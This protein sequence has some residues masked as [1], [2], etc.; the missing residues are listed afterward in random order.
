MFKIYK[1]LSAVL[2]LFASVQLTN[3]QAVKISGVVTARADGQPL[4][5]VSIGVTGSTNGT[6]TD[7]QGKF[8]LNANAN[9]ILRISYIGF[10]TQ[11]IKVT[12][13][14]NP[15]QI[16]LQEAPNSLNE[17]VV[18]ALN[19]SKDKKSLGYAVQGLKSKDISE[20]KETNLVNALSGKIAGLQVTGSQGDM[21]SSRIIIRGETSV[22]GNNQPLFVVDGVI[23]D[24]SQFQGTNGSRDF[25]NAIADL[26]PEDIESMSVLKGPN[27][28]A[29]YGSRAAA[30]VILIK[31][32]TGKGTKGLGITINSNTSFATLKVFPDYQNQFGQGSNGR[33]SYVDGKGGGINDGVDESWGPPLDGRLIP[34]FYSNG[35]AVPFVAHPNNVRDF[36]NTGVTLNNGVA[37]AGSGEKFDYRVSYNNLHQTGVVPNS[38]QGRNSIMLNST[39]RPTKKLT[40]TTIANYIKDDAGNLPGAYGRRA[41]STML[42]FTWFGRQVDINR[43]KNYRDANGNTFNWNNSYYSNPYFIAYENTVAQHKNRIIGSVELNYKII[44][45]LSANFRTGTDYYNDRRKIKVAYG[46]NGTPFGSYEEDAYTVNETNTEARLQYTKKLN[47]DFSFDGFLG[48]NISTILN[49]QND[50]IAPKLAVAGLYTLS[51]SRDPLVSSNYYGKLKTYSYFASAQIG[52]RNYAFLNLTGRNDWSSTLATANLSYF[53][54]SINGSLV[55]SEALDWK[56][57]ALS[58]LKL[59]GGWSKVGKATT[60]Y[61]L[62]NTYNFTAPFGTNPQQSAAS[63]NLN[64]DLKPETTTSGEAGFEAGFLRDRI[65]LDVSVYNTNSVNQILNVDVSPTTGYTQKLIN[66]GRINNKGLEVQ[67]SATPVKSNSFTWD[68]TVN[69]SRNKSKVV[70]L[71]DDGQLQSYILG[72]NRTVQVLAAVGQP[73]GTLFGNAYTRDASGQIVIGAN[74]TPVINPA[75]Q[76]LGK[77][78]PDWLGS[79]NNSFTYK[80]VNLSF[81]VDAR[82]GGSIYSNTN[83]TGTYTGVL[84][85]TLPGRGAA[86]GGLSYYYPG[87]NTSVPAVQVSNGATA[88]AGETVYDDG[89]VFKGVKADG[90]PNTTILSAQSYYKGFTNVDEAFVY[91]ASYVK[92]REV[93]IGYTFP[94]QWVKG[95]GLQSA[96]VSLVGRNLWIIHKNVPN[97]DPET[98]FNTGNGQGLEDLTLP[99]V[100]NIGFNINLKF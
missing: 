36:F 10:T 45:G 96:T 14:S 56:S 66:G 69:Y 94:S 64:P 91:S 71:D 88:P 26:N 84:A 87:N 35:Q 7:V 82:I 89:M 9:D 98:A 99:T 57:D 100:R 3:A 79:I 5:G 73:Y 24:N 78:T 90:T 13:T 40:V 42:Q 4:P 47:K 1:F 92:L 19:I 29:L 85:S 68:V 48:G 58:Y 41:T 80:G 43:L 62:I 75:K 11:E 27:A 17:V 97:I 70:S 6:Q 25:Q 20:A 2:L 72:T 39:F 30:G 77:Y 12:N 74:G 81:L 28:A 93:K 52:F 32:K 65:R 60:P 76:Y 23:V 55:V 46:T 15:L 59:R 18:T 95:V 63:I 31:T 16:V 53:Y 67:L 44:D 83:R 51:N 22:S 34:Q 54:P 49:E 21:G 38:S 8:T 61:Q 86:N 33:F 37:L 50:Q